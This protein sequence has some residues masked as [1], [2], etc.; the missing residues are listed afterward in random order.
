MSLEAKSDCLESQL[1]SKDLS[2][3]ER[4]LKAIN[5]FDI[6]TKIKEYKTMF[7]EMSEEEF[8]GEMK[9]ALTL[10]GVEIRQRENKLK[11]FLNIRYTMVTQMLEDEEVSLS[12]VYIDLTIVKEEP[13]PVKLEDE[14]TCNEIAYLRK[15][16]RK[17]IEITP[18]DFKDEL[19]SY[20]TEKP[21]IWYLSVCIRTYNNAGILFYHLPEIYLLDG[22]VHECPI[23]SRQQC[24]F[25]CVLDGC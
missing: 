4:A 24:S 21:E 5:R 17:E 23:H 13:R 7:V 3:L 11:Q 2:Y 20:K 19:K 6:V 18:A 22:S 14:T 10:Q 8:I 25:L 15:I 16:A 1:I 9:K 12:S